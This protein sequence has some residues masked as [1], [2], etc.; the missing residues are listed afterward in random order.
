MKRQRLGWI[1]MILGALLFGCRST[2]YTTLAF[3]AYQAKKELDS[4]GSLHQLLARAKNELNDSLAKVIAFSVQAYRQQPNVYTLENWVADAVKF[5]AEKMVLTPVDLVLISRAAVGKWL[6]KGN[7]RLQDFF[8]LIPDNYRWIIHRV[9]VDTLET[10]LDSALRKNGFGIAGGTLMRDSNGRIQLKVG[11]KVLHPNTH[12][13]LIILHR[14][15]YQPAN[16]NFV[17][18]FPILYKG[19]LLRD[20][21]IFY[22]T[23]FTHAGQPL[24]IS[25][26]KRIDV[27]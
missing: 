5:T 14:L 22:A 24:K 26:E 2:G 17:P 19:T 12:L 7:I 23:S 9:R 4:T 25:I 1:G 21:V 3:S 20:A 15:S 11:G 6:P 10:L 8:Q 13:H 18:I 27:Q 16:E